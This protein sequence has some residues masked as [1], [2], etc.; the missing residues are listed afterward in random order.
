[1]PNCSLNKRLFGTL[2][3]AAV[4]PMGAAAQDA[5]QARFRSLYQELIETDTSL[6]KG[7]CTL[8]A[9][10]MKARLVAA[11]YPGSQFRVVVPSEFPKQGNLVGEIGGSDAN[12]TAILLVAH[13]DVVEAKRED[14]QRDPFK[15]VEENG[16]FFA[17]GA[18][19]D[20]AMAAIFVD[21][22]IRYREEKYRPR[23]TIKLALT[24]GEE[25]DAVFDGVRYLL[26]TEP[27]TL[28]AGLAIN[29]GGK[30]RLDDQG[31]PRTFGVQAG[32]KIYQDFTLV[33]SG[34]GGHSARPHGNN[35]IT[36]LAEGLARIGHHRFPAMPGEVT[37]SFFARSAPL[38]PGEKGEAMHVVGRGDDGTA[39]E[40]L[41]NADPVWNAMIRTTCINTQVAGGHAPNAVP[42]RA[43]ATVNCRLLPGTNVEAVQKALVEVVADP[44]IE[45]V[46]AD[47]PGPVSPPP[48]IGPEIMK[49]IEKL[50]AEMWPGVPVIPQLST[51][52][53]DG[54]FLMAAGIPTYGVSGIFV[55]PDGNG[56]HGLD[57]RVRVKS[58]Y[59]ARIF[60]HRLVK[61]YASK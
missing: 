36:R 61:A 39:L 3:A 5:G 20:K 52:A 22:L 48:P 10:R 11:G 34:P 2:L 15:L 32:E 6:S 29:E 44:A 49:P 37:R 7:S 23:R 4:L 14:W 21:S 54:R 1:M 30:G 18:I 12:A 43:Q 42:Q 28:R 55:D 57:E 35:P 58:L 60:L 26:A 13:I 19:D 25:T 33:T 41:S 50:V 9:E 31:K 46:L 53:T 17:R 40:L 27:G 38:Y 51:G 8:A 47:A 59:D 56:T 16:Y 45:V 24:C